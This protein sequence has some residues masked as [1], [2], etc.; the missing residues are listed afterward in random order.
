M[1]WKRF[2][3]SA[4]RELFI[5]SD[6]KLAA[7]MR[8]LALILRKHV[9]R[10]LLLILRLADWCLVL[11]EHF[12]EPLSEKYLLH[13]TVPSE[14]DALVS[15]VSSTISLLSEFFDENLSNAIFDC[16]VSCH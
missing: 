11:V 14:G 16:P 6:K 12:K 3:T 2:K 10:N 4:K 13:P 5:Q 7:G 15:E 9:M 8:L 1:H